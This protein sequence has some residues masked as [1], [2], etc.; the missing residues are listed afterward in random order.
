MAESS[1]KRNWLLLIAIAALV[2]ILWDNGSSLF[3][4]NWNIP[5]FPIVIVAFAIWWMSGGKD[6]SECCGGSDACCQQDDFAEDN[7]DDSEHVDDE[8]SANNG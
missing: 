7:R 6:R 5:V 3:H 4:F 8:E 1:D 2:V